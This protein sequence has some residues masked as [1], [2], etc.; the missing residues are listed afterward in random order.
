MGFRQASVGVLFALCS[1]YWTSVFGIGENQ[2][3]KLIVDASGK[4]GRPIPETLFGIFFEV[5][6]LPF[7]S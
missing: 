1:L 2:T 3:T 7:S 5:N 6:H 4:S